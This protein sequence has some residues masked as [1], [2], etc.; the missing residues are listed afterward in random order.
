MA[1]QDETYRIT[2]RRGDRFTF[3]LRYLA[4][5]TPVDLTGFEAEMIISW[6]QYRTGRNPVVEAGQILMSTTGGDI[7]LGGAQGTIE[8][9]RDA[10]DPDPVPFGSPYVGWQLRIYSTELDKETLLSGGVDVL[11]NLFEGV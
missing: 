2:Y 6:P 4:D 9:A 11:N 8:V 1:A 5:G 7:T 10:A 3:S